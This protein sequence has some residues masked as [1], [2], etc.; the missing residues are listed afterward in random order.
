VLFGSNAQVNVGGL[1]ASTLDISDAN[2]NAGVN[3]GHYVF[4]P[5]TTG[6]VDNAGTITATSG[7]L[8]ALLGSEVSNE[9]AINAPQGT[10]GLGAGSQITLDI[11]SDGLTQL[12]IN[13]AADDAGGVTATNN[14]GGTLV[15]DGGQVLMQAFNLDGSNSYGGV[16]NNGLVQARSLQSRNGRIVL[17]SSSV[18][19]S[20]DA[21][22]MTGTLDVGGTAAG[23]AG[24]S[25]E[26]D[27]NDIAITP[28]VSCVGCA[29]SIP[30]PAVLNASGTSAGGTINITARNVAEIDPLSSFQADA[31]VNGN[32]GSIVVDGANGLYGLGAFSAKGGANG[33]NGGSIETSGGGLD[34]NG[35]QVDASAAHGNAGTWL[36][37]PY[38]V[39]IM[40]GSAVGTLPI[41]PPFVPLTGTTIQDGDINYALNGGSN[42]TIT[43]GTSGST[44]NGSITI[45]RIVNILRTAG[46]APL[47]FRL[48]AN[49]N[50][51]DVNS[52]TI[53]STAGALN[54]VFD[55]NANSVNTNNGD[56]SFNGA[57]LLTNGG[58]IAMFG[59]NDPVSGFAQSFITGISL[60]QSTL[61]T[62][63]AGNDANPGGAIS[64]RGSAGYY[65]GGTGVSLSQTDLHSSSG[66]IDIFGMG[67]GGGSGV[68]LAASTLGAAS[69]ITTTSGSLAITGIGSSGGF[70]SYSWDGLSTVNYALQSTTG[71]IDLRG[72]GAV[73]G[74]SNGSTAAV[75]N[76][77]LVLDSLTAVRSGSGN[78]YLSGSSAGSGAGVSLV[79]TQVSRTALA[80]ATV[81]S[82]SGNIVVRAHNDGTTDALV[83]NGTLASASM[84]G[85]RPGGVDANGAL[86]EN[87][88]DAI[89]LGGTTGFA[90][91]AAEIGNIAAHDLVLGSDSQAGAITV[92][93]PITYAHNLT[94][95]SAA[96]GG[97]AI[98]GAL[99][100]GMNT[101]AL[102]SAGNI[103][104]TAP[105]TAASLLAQSGAGLVNLGNA[106]NNVSANTVA[107]TAASD[108]TFINAGDVG[109]GPVSALGFAT[110]TN[111]PSA[112]AASG[113][114][115]G[116][117]VLA[118]SLSGNLLL[119]GNVSGNTVNLVADSPTG[120]FLNN[121]GA[122]IT[123]ASYWHVWASSWVGENRG[124]L[125]GT[126][127]LPNLYGCAFS[128][129]CTVTP[130]S[131]A[132]QF[133]YIAQPVATIAIDNLSRE[134]G[135]LN[136]ALTYV[137]SGLI[138]GDQAVNAISG[139]PT[140]AATQASSVGSYAINGNFTS[141]AGYLLKIANGTL[142]ITPATLTY[143]ADPQRRL[144]GAPNGALGGNVSGFRNGDT[145]ATA[146]TGIQAFQTPAGID[147]PIG[148][149]GIFGTGLNANNYVFAQANGNAQA[150]VITP[151]LQAYTLDIQRDTPVTYVYDR[152]FGMVGL[153]PATDLASSSRDQDGDTLA[154]EWSRV[155]SRPNLANCVSTKQKNSCGDF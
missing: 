127:T 30:V 44:T 51:S 116:G 12:T 40:H 99:N 4:G 58:S 56:I 77:G 147:S 119:N 65:G 84:I 149:Y 64:L 66:N 47:T 80:S 142:A 24:G 37:D 104:Q 31:T 60:S 1:V 50:I 123:A 20:S 131:T 128:A 46:T 151:P 10:I 39:S 3:S 82:G 122:S 144:V 87:P 152:N 108:F 78:V 115:A 34:I 48:D 133:I 98:N 140:T 93:T 113:I 86:T 150:L 134:Y 67:T 32:G 132:N 59:Q 18:D 71:T 75:S 90:L 148:V 106:G 154:R 143:T 95:D 55:S 125:A 91:S 42:V 88:S 103:T 135:L 23:V 81:N 36:I 72:Y 53:Q 130:L 13:T 155:R 102:V 79:S 94:L 62:R 33:G 76:H 49:T 74:G 83:L 19:G 139:N 96:G 85:L 138:L 124:G 17:S 61:D 7:G 97:I 141:P 43:T 25:V 21:V 8:V 118:Q 2:F 153:C 35:I 100:V 92:S 70:Q 38:D 54:L 145:M 11:G 6:L 69:L 121:T 52:F 109:I 117:N 105:V 41:N 26:I 16:V 9:G 146:T 22:S 129:T 111:A 73:D 89:A 101:L 137:T 63:V 45:N 68:S 29:F 114:T 110:A 107:G 120:L 27:G 57:N 28:G 136:P 14:H 5:G 112:L 126:G 15:A